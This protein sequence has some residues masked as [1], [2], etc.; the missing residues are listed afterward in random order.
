MHFAQDSLEIK[1]WYSEQ[2]RAHDCEM[3][4]VFV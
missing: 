4:G 3:D 1:P 2:A